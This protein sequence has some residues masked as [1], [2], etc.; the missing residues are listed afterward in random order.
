M[1][2]TIAALMV[3]TAAG[4]SCHTIEPGNKGV[5][6][7]WGELQEPALNPGFQTLGP[8][9]DIHDVSIR[10]HKEELESACFSSDLQQVK[11]KIAILYRIPENQ[12]LRIFKEY[13]GSPFEVLVAPRT[14]EALKEATASRSAEHIVKERESVKTDALAALR[15]K[16]NGE[17]VDG[18]PPPNDILV[19]ED[20]IIENIDLSKELEVA[21]EQ[22]MVQQ[23]EAAKAEFT[24]QKAA[25][26]AE[27]A[28]VT[29]QGEANSTLARARAEAEA[30]KIRGDALAKNP[31]VIQLE[32]INKWKGDVPQVVSGSNGTNIL[33]PAMQSSAK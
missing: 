2:T 16:I 22:K 21:I 19:I 31:A 3:L 9:S 7:I 4:C 14:Q 10:S 11:I 8:G 18:G 13:N 20:L 30:I 28:L 32:L 12:V 27:R 26:D 23:Q 6:V 29:A 15:K 24:K 17:G 5:K 25:I 1:K 33:L